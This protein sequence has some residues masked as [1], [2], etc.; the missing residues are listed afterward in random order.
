MLITGILL[1]VALVA[2]IV[3]A[4]VL[5]GSKEPTRTSRAMVRENRETLTRVEVQPDTAV[6]PKALPPE[7]STRSATGENTPPAS[8][9][10]PLTEEYATT[11]APHTVNLQPL[12]EHLERDYYLNGQ[13]HEMLSELETL[14]QQAADLERRLSTLKEMAY[15]IER[16][17]HYVSAE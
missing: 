10:L 3:L 4:F 13:F 2:L 15:H 8:E 12:P 14:H 7:K 1:G 11:P 16:S 17:Q 6:S 9:E 5:V